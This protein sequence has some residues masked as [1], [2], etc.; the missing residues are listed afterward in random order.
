MSSQIPLTI[1]LRDNASLQ[2]YFPGPNAEV[3]QRLAASVRGQASDGSIYLWGAD[4][5]GKTHLLQAVC[6]QA[7][8]DEL[9][10]AYLSLEQKSEFDPEMLEGLEQM[11]VVCIDDLQHLSGD[12][13]WQEALFHLYNRCF[14]SGC[15]LIFAADRNIAELQLALPDLSS[16]LAWGFVFQLR[17]L[18]DEE[19]LAALQLR[20]QQ[21]GF[22]L[23]ENAGQYLLRR[24]P[25]DMNALFDTLDALD[26]ASLAAKRRL[27]LPFVKAWLEAGGAD[28]QG[29]LF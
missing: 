29:S 23:P 11:Q 28:S 21:R 20:A 27:T 18:S 3:H 22:D 6:Q 13:D 24:C 19:K 7:A 9:P 14:D 10:A 8:M 26:K 12:R 25:R 1:Q 17:S 2:N 5:T 16:R 4:G 15:Q